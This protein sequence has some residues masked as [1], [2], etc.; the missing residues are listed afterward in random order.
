MNE[1]K[2]DGSKHGNVD[3][4]TNHGKTTAKRKET[5]PSVFFISV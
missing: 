4:Q 2:G 5:Y 1:Y 3:H